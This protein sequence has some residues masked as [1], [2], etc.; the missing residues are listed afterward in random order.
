MNSTNLHHLCDVEY[1]VW[2]NP[3]LIPDAQGR[4]W[5][6]LRRKWVIGTPEEYVRQHFLR[7][8][9][10]EAHY[11]P[12]VIAVER[13]LSVHGQPKRFDAV[14]FHQGKPWMLVECKAPHIP[15][16][17]AVC[18]Q[19]MRYNLPLEAPWGWLTNGVTDRFFAA[20]GR[21]LPP[22]LP[23]FGTFAL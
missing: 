20:D 5:D 21:E 2:P 19:W 6:A 7:R 17:D 3:K 15:L 11:P 8:A 23:A 13:G 1:E 16:N 18:V 9:I 22:V 12:E 14:V 4:L 10:L